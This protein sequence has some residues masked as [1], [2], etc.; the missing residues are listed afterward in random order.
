MIMLKE[1]GAGVRSL[2]VWLRTAMS[3]ECFILV[4]TEM[5]IWIKQKAK[6]FLKK[7]GTLISQEGL[8]FT[9]DY[10]QVIHR[11]PVGKIKGNA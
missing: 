8:R 3:V 6:G 2:F 10:M 11:I 1:Y 7:W 9:L 5:R 4:K